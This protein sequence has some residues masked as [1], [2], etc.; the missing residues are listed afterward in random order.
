MY[1][2]EMVSYHQRINLKRNRIPAESRKEE[3]GG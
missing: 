3:N 1:Y 2:G